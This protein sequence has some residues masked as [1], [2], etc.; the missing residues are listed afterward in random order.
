MQ[1][2]FFVALIS[3]AVFVQAAPPPQLGGTVEGHGLLGTGIGA[4]KGLLGTSLLGEGLL[5]TGVRRPNS[6]ILGQS[7]GSAEGGEGDEGGTGGGTEARSINGP[8]IRKRQGGFDPSAILG[9]V[10]GAGADPVAIVG[11][12]TGAAGGNTPAKPQDK[13]SDDDDEALMDKPIH[14]P[15]DHSI[16]S[17]C[18]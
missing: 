17:A 5:G 2:S 13:A 10:T 11:A 16:N 8:V 18:K 3:L 7:E 9:G 1:P 14:S 12:V 4:P 6:G 15:R